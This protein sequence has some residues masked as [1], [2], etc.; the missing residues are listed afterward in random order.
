MPKSCITK[1]ITVKILDFADIH[2][3]KSLQSLVEVGD[4]VEFSGGYYDDDING[5]AWKNGLLHGN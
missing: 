2:R 5:M 3:Y 1:T 4:I